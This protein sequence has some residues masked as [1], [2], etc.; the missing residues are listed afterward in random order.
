[1]KR[2]TETTKWDDPWFRKLTPAAKLLWQ[3]ML[4]HCDGAGV[5]DPDLELASFQTG[6][7][8]DNETLCELIG[9]IE[10]LECGKYHIV[11]FVEFQYGVLS[12]DCKAHRPVIQSLEKHQIE[13]V[14]KGYPKG[15]QRVQ[16]KEKEKEKED[17]GVQRGKFT[18]P[19]LDQA[20][21]VAGQ[22]GVSE[23]QAEEWWNAREASDWFRA[24]GNT[25]TPV[26]AN[27]QAD[28]KTYTNNKTN[29]NHR[30]NPKSDPANRPGRYA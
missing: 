20:R 4:D 19:T 12:D 10:R 8:T 22:V 2:F 17:G 16:E 28:L 26:G 7:S 13:R 9:R 11:K 30:T 1:M 21:S 27:W 5:I 18:R 15:I 29:G 3:W 14:S 23:K 6:C 25:T 24:S